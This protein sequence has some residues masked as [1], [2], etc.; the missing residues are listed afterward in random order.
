[1]ARAERGTNILMFENKKYR[2][3]EFIIPAQDTKGH[4]ERFF[5]RIPPGMMRDLKII[6]E[7]KRFPFRTMGDI[8]RV[9]IKL[10]IELLQNME[11]IPSVNQQVDTIAG[12]VRD[13]EWHQEF[14]G[15]FELVGR[16]INRYIAAGEGNQARRLLM[17]I[18]DEIRAMPKGYWR[19]KYWKELNTKYGH[20]LKDA[21]AKLD[22]GEDDEVDPDDLKG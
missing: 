14:V 20:I 16:A 7:S 18:R 11:P 8:G 1:M 6:K 5:C 15:T 22:E 17:K 12:L 9:A 4:S 19:S 3:E 13:E 2:E 10:M 21:G